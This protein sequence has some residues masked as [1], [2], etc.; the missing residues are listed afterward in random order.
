MAVHGLG[1]SVV[2]AVARPKHPHVFGTYLHSLYHSNYRLSR[3]IRLMNY[4][5]RS[6]YIIFKW[7]T[8]YIYMQVY[9]Q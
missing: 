7:Y 6:Y 3:L 4:T 9:M 8:V 5:V 2:K 1:P